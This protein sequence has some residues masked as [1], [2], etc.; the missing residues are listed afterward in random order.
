MKL[1]DGSSVVIVEGLSIHVS[2]GLERPKNRLKPLLEEVSPYR[3][4]VQAGNSRR[5]RR[6]PT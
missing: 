3:L 2:V 5:C 1:Q 4:C 6:A